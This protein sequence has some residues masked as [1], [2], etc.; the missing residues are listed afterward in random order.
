MVNINQ[1]KILEI[2]RESSK[3]GVTI[4]TIY[5]KLGIRPKARRDQE[6]RERVLKVLDD[7]VRSGRVREKK[8][9][10]TK[11]YVYLGG[12]AE[13]DSRD[14]VVEPTKDLEDIVKRAVLEALDIFFSRN[15][16]DKTENDFDKI[17]DE[18]KDSFG[19]ARLDAIRK[20]LGMTEEQFYGR[21]RE[22]ILKDYQ[23]LSGGAEGLILSGILYGIIKKKR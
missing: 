11:R 13:G 7:L 9:G 10:K 17:Y 8:S 19:L 12:P 18:V 1:D 15:N 6:E 4:S 16:K 20:Q 23:L 21:F 22:H 14:K 5:E 3:D 2:L